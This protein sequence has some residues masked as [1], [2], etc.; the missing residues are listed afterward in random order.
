[1]KSSELDEEVFK[2]FHKGFTYDEILSLLKKSGV[3]I[4]LSTLKRIIYSLNLKSKYLQESEIEDICLAILEELEFAGY[5]LGY[6]ALWAK[7][8]KKYYLTWLRRF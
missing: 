2:L 5:N 6:R 7:L 8:K 4:S 1:M 3:K